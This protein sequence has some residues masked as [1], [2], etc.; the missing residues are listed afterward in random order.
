[1]GA[2]SLARAV[3]RVVE[4]FPD[5]TS[6]L[7]LQRPPEGTFGFCVAYGSGRRDSGMLSG[8]SAKYLGCGQ[9]PSRQ[10]GKAPL[11]PPEALPGCQVPGAAP[12]EGVG[13]ADLTPMSPSRPVTS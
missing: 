6:Q 7:Q 3:G 8:S 10:W 9:V 13:L 2:P 4:V 12:A 1:M 11:V 5:G